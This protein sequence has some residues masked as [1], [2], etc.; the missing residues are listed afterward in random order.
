M[1]RLLETRAL[2]VV[3]TPAPDLATHHL[4]DPSTQSSIVSFSRLSLWPYPSQEEEKEKKSKQR[5]SQ[6]RSPLTL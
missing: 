4:L 3:R 2:D 5:L 6:T 1:E